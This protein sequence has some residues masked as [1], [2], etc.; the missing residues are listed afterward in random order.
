MHKYT[1]THICFFFVFRFCLTF[2]F[3]CLIFCT[4]TGVATMLLVTGEKIFACASASTRCLVLRVCRFG[5]L[6]S[7]SLATETF[8]PARDLLRFGSACFFRL[9]NHSRILASQIAS[10]LSNV[11][12]SKAANK[13]TGLNNQ[14]NRVRQESKQ[15][16]YD[17]KK[18]KNK[19]SN[20]HVCQD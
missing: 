19:L 11:S 7:T 5:V 9:F 14:N 12:C 16:M 13:K 3:F 20:L 2:L 8:F 10:A 18:K 15:C 1:N 6:P 4:A 17:T